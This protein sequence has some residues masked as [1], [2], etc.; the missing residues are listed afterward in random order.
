M[1]RDK[2]DDRNNEAV[3]KLEIMVFKHFCGETWAWSFCYGFVDNAY[4]EGY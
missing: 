2:N 1:T 4:S 3:L